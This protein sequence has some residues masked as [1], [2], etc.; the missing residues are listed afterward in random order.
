MIFGDE[1]KLLIVQIPSFSC[2]FIPTEA[3]I[4]K[5]ARLRKFRIRAVVTT[6]YYFI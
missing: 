4:A 3:F 6:G 5:T 2:Y 1:C